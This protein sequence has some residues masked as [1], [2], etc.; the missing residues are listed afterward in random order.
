MQNTQNMMHDAYT[1]LDDMGVSG[2][3]LKSAVDRRTA[4][5]MSGALA[6]NT[7][8]S[9]NTHNSLCGIKHSYVS[10]VQTAATMSRVLSTKVNTTPFEGQKPGTSGLRKKVTEFQKPH[11]TENFVQ[12]TLSALGDKLAGCTLV[13]GGDGRFFTKQAVDII[14]KMAAA[15]GVSLTSRVVFFM[16]F[17]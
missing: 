14:I 6:G 16:S 7:A 13:V 11:Y 2:Q 17:I 4:A 1:A 8:A 10:A 9:S 3:G 5:S 12:S 15:N